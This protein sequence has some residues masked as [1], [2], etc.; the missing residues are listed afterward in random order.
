VNEKEPF[1]TGRLSLDEQE[2]QMIELGIVEDA[3]P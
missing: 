1:H 3:E 2:G